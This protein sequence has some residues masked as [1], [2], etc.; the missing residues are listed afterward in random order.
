[1][2]RKIIITSIIALIALVLVSTL[3]VA[4]SINSVEGQLEAANKYIMEGD[5]EK[6]ILAFEK[7]LKI[8]ENNIDARMGLA[9]VYVVTGETVKAI[10]YLEEVIEIDG[11][12]V[13]AYT[14]LGRI[15]IEEGR[16]EEAIK[17]L[18]QG[19]ERTGKESIKFLLESAIKEREEKKFE[20]DQVEPLAVVD[21]NTEEELEVY[22]GVDVLNVREKPSR[23]SNKIGT[24]LINQSFIA[25]DES[26][27]EDGVIWYLVEYSKDQWG[28]IISQYCYTKAEASEA[29]VIETIHPALDYASRGMIEGVEVKIGDTRK[30]MLSVYGN[31]DVVDSFLGGRYNWY[32]NQGIE[33]YFST[34]DDEDTVS[35]IDYK[36]ALP[37]IDDYISLDELIEK[38]GVPIRNSAHEEFDYYKDAHGLSTTYLIYESGEYEITFY[39]NNEGT[40]IEYTWIR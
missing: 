12:Y 7:V 23:S 36:G 39:F 19:M 4:R 16:L 27:D 21:E 2:N 40:K 26:L 32:K 29:E 35:L 9:G 1:M 30:K 14:E 37:G 34:D 18:E 8:D 20:E 11:T 31:P 25:K 5:Y 13:E 24:V 3:L 38:I 22:V 15:L 10:K 28:W 6:A 17:V 33:F